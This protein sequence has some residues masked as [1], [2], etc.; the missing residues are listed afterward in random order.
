MAVA[1]S[2]FVRMD[3]FLYMPEIRA[4][5]A[6]KWHLKLKDKPLEGSWKLGC[7]VRDPGSD[8]NHG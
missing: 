3:I 2:G 6:K 4:S 5:I 7:G 8:I 1:H